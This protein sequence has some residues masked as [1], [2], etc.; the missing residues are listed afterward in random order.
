MIRCIIFALAVMLT[1]GPAIADSQMEIK[2]AQALL[3]IL[4]YEAG[5]ADGV[6]GAAT[7]QAIMGKADIKPA[8]SELAV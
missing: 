8:G 7:R 2:A 5:P 3:N 1:S 4:G 6:M